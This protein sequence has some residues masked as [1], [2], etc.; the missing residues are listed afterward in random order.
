MENRNKNW[1]A[2]RASFIIWSAFYSLLSL[3]DAPMP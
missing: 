1:L 2:V 3:A